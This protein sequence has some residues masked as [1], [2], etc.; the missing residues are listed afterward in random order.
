MKNSFIKKLTR[1]DPPRVKAVLSF[2]RV[3]MRR[4]REP[5]TC[6]HVCETPVQ[7][8]KI[9]NIGFLV[10]HK[11]TKDLAIYINLSIKLFKANITTQY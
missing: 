2:G 11:S 9:T 6:V 1:K 5:R 8:R 4:K 10:S 3:Y 7:T